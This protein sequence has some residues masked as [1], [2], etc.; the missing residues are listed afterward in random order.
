MRGAHDEIRSM[1][2]T[3]RWLAPMDRGIIRDGGVA[4]ARGIITAVGSARDVVAA[5]RDADVID[6]GESLLLPGLVNAHTHLE[7]SNCAPESF[8][9]GSFADW[10]L[11]L[12]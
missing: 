4:F 8:V 10:I 3:A 2:L 1:I 6:L 9:G 12:P 5:Y 7:L 11:S